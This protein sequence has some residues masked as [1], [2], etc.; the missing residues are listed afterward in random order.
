KHP[1]A[2]R[3]G[4][5]SDALHGLCYLHELYILHGDLK[6]TNILI[7][8]D[9]VACLADLGLS[10][11]SH[12]PTTNSLRGS[13][14]TQ[15]MSP[16]ILLTEDARG[17]QRIPVKTLESDIFAF[18]LV[19]REV[20]GDER[21]YAEVRNTAYIIRLIAG[22][23]T[24]PRPDNP[25]ARQWLCDKM[26]EIVQLAT[27]KDPEA[28]PVAAELEKQFHSVPLSGRHT[29]RRRLSETENMK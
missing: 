26:W 10:R 2:D 12:E 28:R 13:G 9:G 1:D 7:K 22:G 14:S 15:Y 3:R 21:P 24:L 6:G 16:E 23:Y 20:L 29:P 11:T 19:I 5:I 17:V 4:I 27:H 18:G 8:D 25:V